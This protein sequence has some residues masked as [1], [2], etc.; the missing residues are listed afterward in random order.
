MVLRQ[1]FT[2]GGD[3]LLLL[4][5]KVRGCGAEQCSVL[6]APGIVHTGCSSWKVGLGMLLFGVNSVK[7]W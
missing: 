5:G 4:E 3:T 1:Y 6:L 2:Q 7:Q